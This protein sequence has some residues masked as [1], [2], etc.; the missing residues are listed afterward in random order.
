MQGC[1][2]GV[3]TQVP[4]GI[5]LSTHVG[6]GKLGPLCG[7][8]NHLQLDQACLQLVTDEVSTKFTFQAQSKECY[9]CSFW[10]IGENLV[11]GTWIP[12]NTTY[13]TSFKVFSNNGTEICKVCI[14]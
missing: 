1:F 9:K 14:I 3:E 8:V 4:K 10:T 13:P 11:N 2:Q 5:F 6:G 7:E 12:V